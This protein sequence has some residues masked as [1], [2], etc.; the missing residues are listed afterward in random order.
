MKIKANEIFLL[1]CLIIYITKHD[2]KKASSLEVVIYIYI[3]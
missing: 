2:M 3:H 1:K